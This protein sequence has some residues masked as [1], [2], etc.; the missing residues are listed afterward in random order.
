MPKE[1]EPSLVSESEYDGMSL[2]EKGLTPLSWKDFLKFLRQYSNLK[3]D[4]ILISACGSFYPWVVDAQDSDFSRLKASEARAAEPSVARVPNKNPYSP[5]W[6]IELAKICGQGAESALSLAFPLTLSPGAE[7]LQA[8]LLRQ[9]Q[10][11]RV[12][13]L[14]TTYPLYSKKI[15]QDLCDLVCAIRHRKK[16]KEM[17]V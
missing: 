4:F 3:T 16:I 6:L 1:Q 9:S 13:L 15:D 10:V 8:W 7:D 14:A 17:M 12:P 11:L 2:G 5:F